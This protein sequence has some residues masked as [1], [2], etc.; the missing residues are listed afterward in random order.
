MATIRVS[1]KGKVLNPVV[2]K[3]ILAGN[4]EDLEIIL[5]NSLVLSSKPS[6]CVTQIA[7]FYLN[8]KEKYGDPE[9]FIKFLSSKFDKID[10]VTQKGRIEGTLIHPRLLQRIKE[11]IGTYQKVELYRKGL[12]V[13]RQ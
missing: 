5:D 7:K 11:Y 12:L 13:P 3:I 4:Q 2:S 1:T 6:F 9:E 10:L 8:N